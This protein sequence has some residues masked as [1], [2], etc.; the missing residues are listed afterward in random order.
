MKAKTADRTPEIHEQ[1][2]KSHNSYGIS[3]KINRNY[4]GFDS[5]KIYGESTGIVF[6]KI[7]TAHLDEFHF[8]WLKIKVSDAAFP[9]SITLFFNHLKLN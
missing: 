5:E 9:I 4:N 8:R 1:Y 7:E 6:M 2:K 3:E